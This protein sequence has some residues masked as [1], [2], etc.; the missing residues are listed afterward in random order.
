M[1]GIAGVV[2]FDNGCPV[3]RRLLWRVTRALSHR[4][5]DDEAFYCDAGVGLGHRRL[6][7]IDLS[8]EARHPMSNEDRTLWLVGNG[9]IYNYRELRKDLIADGHRFRTGSDMEVILHLY[10]RDGEAAVDALNGMF[11]FAIWDVSRRRLFAARDRLGIKP[12]YFTVS[13]ERLLFASEPKALVLHGGVPRALD[14]EGLA[15]YARFQFYLGDRTLFRGIRRL[16]PGH[17]LTADTTGR[18]KT[19]V[20]WQPQYPIS[21]IDDGRHYAEQLGALLDDAV[22]LELRSDV[23][24]GTH[25]SGGMDSATVATIAARL[26]A[27]G[28]DMFSG[29]FAEAGYDERLMASALAR[30]LGGAHHTVEPGPADFVALMPQLAAQMD[31]PAAGPGMFP[32]FVVSRMARSRV[33]VSLSGH[34][35]DEIFGGYIRYLVAYLERSLNGG[36]AGTQ[37]SRK[38]VVTFESILPNLVQLQGYEPMLRAFWRDGLFGPEDERYLQLIDRSDGLIEH[39]N[40]DLLPSPSEYD[41]WQTAREHWKQAP[42]E[43]LINKMT[44]FDMTTVL[45]ALLQVEDRMSMAV[46]LESRTPLLDHRIVEF[47][48]TVPPRFKY[49]GGRSK[50]LLR[51]VMRSQLPAGWADQTRKMGFPVPLA[52]WSTRQP[53]KDFLGDVFRS[54]DSGLRLDRPWAGDNGSQAPQSFDRSMWGLLSLELWALAYLRA[55]TPEPSEWAVAPASMV[56][57]A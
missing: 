46:G 38:F 8:P 16:L 34:G 51:E 2:N 44:W 48:G 17:V 26:L 40:P 52:E 41:P 56:E 49:A 25:L 15:D 37:E 7:V 36:I 35:G 53:V 12:F 19:R 10:E 43:S 39:L 54:R 47:M 9:E 45:P 14:P 22:R 31:Y 30:S 20:F 33:T 4:G 57:Q 21:R 18:V 55:P 29:G 23:P 24:I 13:P 27:R 32:Q 50:H 1:C 3:D 11:A 5:P 28:P 42:C 6:S